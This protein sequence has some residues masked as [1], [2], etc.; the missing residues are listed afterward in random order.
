LRVWRVT[1]HLMRGGDRK[2]RLSHW[3]GNSH[4]LL[5]RAA[6]WRKNGREGIT[7][8]LIITVLDGKKRHCLSLFTKVFHPKTH[9]RRG[10]D[11]SE[12]K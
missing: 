2:L 11:L 1:R 4:E 9:L 10:K 7:V 5:V 8:H 12:F 6:W 3:A